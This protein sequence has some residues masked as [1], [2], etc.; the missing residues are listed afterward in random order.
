MAR[1]DQ[2]HPPG[3]GFRFD[4][5]FVEGASYREPS[6]LEREERARAAE[7]AEQQARD[8]AEREER[9]AGRRERY[10]KVRRFLPLVILI[11]VALLLTR[12]G[13]DDPE[14]APEAPAGETSTAP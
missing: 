8:E 2:E 14:P 10:A 12:L 5:S 1:D 11:L 4:D 9:R 3:E 13:S 6:A 7:E